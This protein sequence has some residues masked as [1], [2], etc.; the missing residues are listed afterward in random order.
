MIA[1]GLNLHLSSAFAAAGQIIKLET[2]DN[3]STFYVGRCFRTDIRVQTDNLNANSVD[4]VLPYN[5]TYVAPYTDSGCTVGATGIVTDNL[6]PSYPANT[7]SGSTIEVTGYDPS[8][9]NPVNTGAAPAD[10]VLGHVYWK[11]LTASGSFHMNFS[12]TLGSTTDTNMAEQGGNG[13]DALDAVQNLSLALADDVSGPTFSSLNPAASATNV[14]VTSGIS[15]TIND[16]GA[17]VNSGSI[18]TKLDGVLK[19]TTKSGCVV[20]NSNRTA[21]CNASVSPGTLNYNTTYTVI[22]SGADLASPTPNKGSQTWQFTTEDDT[23]APYVQNL[24]PASGATGVATSTTIVLHIKDYKN[25]AGVTPGLGVDSS[26]I[27]VTVTAGTGSPIT[28]QQGDGHT[29]ITGISADRTVTITPAAPFAQNQTV[30]VSVDASDLHSPPNVM[31]TDTYSF[32]TADTI[33]PAFFNLSPASGADNVAA[34]SNI[35]FTVSDSGAGI[36]INNTT[37]S[38]NGTSYGVGDS[39]FSYTGTSSSYTITINPASNFTGNQ[40]V[41]VAL[42]ARDL[43]STPNTGTKSY[44]FTI[45]SSCSTCSVDSENPSRFTTS[46]GLSDT[47]AFHVKDSGAGIDSSSIKVKL[48]GTGAAV[49]SSPLV[50]TG[51][52][53]L[54]SITGTS[55]DYAVTITLP[56]AIENNIPYAITIDASDVNGLT[57]STVAYTFMHLTSGSGTTVVTV[58]ASCPATSDTSNPPAGGRRPPVPSTVDNLPAASLPTIIERKQ[59]PDGTYYTQTLTPAEAQGI[60]QC[61]IDVPYHG[62]APALPYKDVSPTDWFASAVQAFV[63]QGILDKTQQFF[64][65]DDSAL[66]SEFAQVLTKLGN[67]QHAVV[68]TPSFDDVPRSAW[69]FQPAEDSA[70][71]G[72]ILGYNN[73]YGTH[74]CDFK[75][76]NTATRAEAIAMIMRFEGIAPMHLAPVFPDVSKDAWY[77]PYL[78]AA[79]DHC[80]LQGEGAAHDAHPNRTINRAEMVT[81]FVRAS[82]HQLYGKDCGWVNA[83]SGKTVGY[84]QQSASALTASVSGIEGGDA[85]LLSILAAS[86]CALSGIFLINRYRLLTR[87]H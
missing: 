77:A 18:L 67:K 23:D 25:D 75:P 60:N 62:A 61:Y 50:L 37:A 86:A 40:T 30:Q 57:M 26:S 47:I 64:R 44:S 28:Y 13:T 72:W 85:S 1:A 27:R 41:T 63:D 59:L 39:E 17:G 46:A 19:T 42:S 29:A 79:A 73:C 54:V 6:F 48:I 11:V 7:I 52:S 68:Q 35:V 83:G 8:G 78:Q 2:S 81:L 65:P 3:G 14:S 4:I 53:P 15:Y 84:Q 21:S 22:A 24:N 9:S 32:T 5:N 33:P 51:S 34:D 49:T 16:A 43:A 10:A 87:W 58:P 38:I 76:A 82:E 66:R 36:D 45:A 74:P 55:A 31:S 70:K 12:F 71:Q 80:I 69:Y 56:A 20:T